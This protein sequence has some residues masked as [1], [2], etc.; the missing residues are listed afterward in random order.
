MWVCLFC[1][2]THSNGDFPFGF[3]LKQQKQGVPVHKETRSFGSL[4][5][6]SDADLREASPLRQL[7]SVSGLLPLGHGRSGVTRVTWDVFGACLKAKWV[8]GFVGSGPIFS[9]LLCPTIG[10]FK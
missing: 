2:K 5:V 1:L 3:L 8:C 9:M 6:K 4:E 7:G 10:P